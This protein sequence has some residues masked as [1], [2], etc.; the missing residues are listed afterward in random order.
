MNDNKN[1]KENKTNIKWKSTGNP[2]W[3]VVS[4][5]DKEKRAPKITGANNLQK[6]IKIEMLKNT[7]TNT[8]LGY[9]MYKIHTFRHG[10]ETSYAQKF[11]THTYTHKLHLL[12]SLN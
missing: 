9:S 5:S 3:W 2:I 6:S 11:K 8:C 1:T 7:I 10:K 4:D 12:H